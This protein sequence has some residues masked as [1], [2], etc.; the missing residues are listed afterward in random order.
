MCMD[1]RFQN[2][3][4]KV[5][6]ALLCNFKLKLKLISRLRLHL[7]QIKMHPTQ[8]NSHHKYGYAT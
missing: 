1:S 2:E 4:N 8:S 6:I 3:N 5:E 7:F